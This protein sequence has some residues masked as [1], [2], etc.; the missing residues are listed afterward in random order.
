VI[1]QNIG[2]DLFFDH[3]NQS[4][5]FIDGVEKIHEKKFWILGEL[6]KNNLIFLMKNLK[7]NR[8]W[9]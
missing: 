9:I 8:E 5:I 6:K 7:L 3:L 1:D 4:K 2:Y